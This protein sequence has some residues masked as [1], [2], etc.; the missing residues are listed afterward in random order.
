[1]RTTPI[2]FAVLFSIFVAPALSRESPDTS[3]SGPSDGDLGGKIEELKAQL[4]DAKAGKVAIIRR[5]LKIARD[6]LKRKRIFDH[7]KVDQRR[8]IKLRPLERRGRKLLRDSVRHAQRALNAHKAIDKYEAEI[9]K[10]KSGPKE[11][12]DRAARK[13]LQAQKTARSRL[14]DA[15]QRLENAEKASAR[16]DAE[17]RKVDA[18]MRALR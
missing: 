13:H 4:K 16:V 10:L 6:R 14:K 9:E 17:M 2:I 8:R 11:G 12:G 7:Q 5:K 3:N 1:M 18:E 15:H